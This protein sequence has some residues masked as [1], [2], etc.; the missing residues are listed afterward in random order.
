MDPFITLRAFADDD[1][2]LLKQWLYAPHVAQWYHDPLD[3]IHEVEERNGAFCW[4][5]HLIIEHEK[6]AVGFCQYY[7]YVHGE[8]TW[9][10][11]TEISGTYSIDYLI[12]ELAFLGKGYGR[13]AVLALIQKIR[14]EENAKRILVQPEPENKASCQTL[15]SC[16]FSFDAANAL[17]RIDL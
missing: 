16:G 17:Y 10:G 7:D 13:A 6:Q 14:S 11:D 9:H 15:L 5:N 3:W 1:M 12:G 2:S 4:L 8:E